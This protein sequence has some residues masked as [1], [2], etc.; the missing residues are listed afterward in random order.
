[1]AC[2]QYRR[3]NGRDRPE[4]TVVA[5]NVA[6]FNRDMEQRALPARLAASARPP[7]LHDRIDEAYR[8]RAERLRRHG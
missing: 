8:E 7:S 3:R 1:M 5:K 2:Y 6:D 4:A